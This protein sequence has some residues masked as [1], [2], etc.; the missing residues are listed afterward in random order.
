MKNVQ[1]DY[2]KE[3][4]LRENKKIRKKLIKKCLKKNVGKKYFETK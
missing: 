1:Y 4:G 2:N 3:R